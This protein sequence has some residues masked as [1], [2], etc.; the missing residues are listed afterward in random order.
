MKRVDIKGP[1]RGPIG[2]TGSEQRIMDFVRTH[3]TPAGACSASLVW[4]PLAGDGSDRKFIRVRSDH[5]TA[6]VVIG[7]EQAENRSYELIGRHLWLKGLGGPEILAVNRP[8]GLFLVEDLG[9]LSLQSFMTAAGPSDRDAMYDRVIELLAELHRRGREGFDPDW[10]YQT[11]YYDRSLVLERETGY[12]MSAFVSGF[13]GLP[14]ASG[15]LTREFEALADA[16]LKNAGTVLMHRDFQSR[17]IMVQD[18][19]PRLLDFQGARLGPPGYDLASFLYDP[20]MASNQA[21]RTGM[22]DDYIRRRA[23]EADFDEQAFRRTYPFLSVCRLLQA[24]GAYG[25]LTRVKGR[26]YF[27]QYIPVAAG[28]LDRLLSGA[29]FARWPELRRLT[30]T[31]RTVLENIS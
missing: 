5:R 29:G 26:H 6:M 18:G 17:N 19:R 7:P 11:G 20:Y 21:L 28:R 8:F 31:V 9:A 22:L 23:G 12:F 25:H 15:A 10:C 30:G 16:A 2:S 4:E 27:E 3:W 13:A 14:G 1:D 24:L